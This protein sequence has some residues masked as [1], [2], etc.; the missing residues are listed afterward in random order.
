MNRSMLRWAVA[1]VLFLI[2]FSFRQ[3]LRAGEG[4][5]AMTIRVTSDAFGE[6]ESI[7]EQYT[8][9]GRDVSP[10]LAWT[11]LPA[12]SRSLALI[13]DD[14]DAPMGNWVHW[15]LYG[16]PPDRSGLAE[17]LPAERSLAGG[18]KQGINDFRRIGYG[19]P[20][21]PP[22]PPHR[23]IFTLYALGIEVDLPPGAT[24]PQL[25]DFMNGHILAKG[26]LTGRFQR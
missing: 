3:M 23:Y 18:G 25:L 5:D 10:P 4:A 17:G 22:G 20:C 14:P 21:P 2:P 19:G 13:C 15:V 9:R 26:R 8:C 24:R 11:G 6:G 1:A 7:P 16:L 12:G